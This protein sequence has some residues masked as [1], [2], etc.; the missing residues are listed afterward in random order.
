MED[1]GSL[2]LKGRPGLPHSPHPRPPCHASWQPHASLPALLLPNKGGKVCPPGTP[3]P[4][5]PL[6]ERLGGVGALEKPEPS[7]RVLLPANAGWLCWSC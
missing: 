5:F 4:S 3:P 7:L 6:E 1:R 2:A